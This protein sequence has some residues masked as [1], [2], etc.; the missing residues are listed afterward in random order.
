MTRNFLILL[1]L[2]IFPINCIGADFVPNN[3]QKIGQG[4]AYYL[5]FIKVYNASLYSSKISGTKDILNA[6]FS[7]CLHLEYEVDI[8]KN[9]FIEVANDVLNDQFSKEQLAS[10]Q[11][12]I[13]TLHQGYRNVTNGD[14]YTLCYNNKDQVTTLSFN[15]EIVASVKSADFAKVYFSIWLA[16][17]DPLDD[18]LRKDLLGAL[19]NKQ[20]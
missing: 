10:V 5:G 12:N 4:E 19:L 8:E 6:E 16:P 3:M 9:D 14:S 18:S 17:K 15:N 1:V 20:S 7:K 13:E 2:I 11:S